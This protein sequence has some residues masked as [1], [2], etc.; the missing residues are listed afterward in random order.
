[1][2]L[3]LECKALCDDLIVKHHQIGN[4]RG[5]KLYNNFQKLQNKIRAKR[6]KLHNSAKQNLYNEFFDNMGNH[7][8]EQNYQGKPVKFE[9]DLTHVLPERKA[10]ADLD[11]KNI[12]VDTVDNVE[13]VEDHI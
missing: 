3:K 6:K 10:P 9:P 8:I 1:M 5:T 12:D 7:I 11:F 2:D 13:L 4:G